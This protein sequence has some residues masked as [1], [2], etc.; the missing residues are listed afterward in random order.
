MH[1]APARQPTQPINILLV[2][3][4]PS[5][6][7][8]VSILIES[9]PRFKVVA[10]AGTPAEAVAAVQGSLHLAIVDLALGQ[11]ETG[12]D[13]IRSLREQRPGLP[14]LVLS[15]H[16]E[17]MHARHALNA[18]ALGYLMKDRATEHLHAAMTAVAA[19]KLWLSEALRNNQE[20][21]A[22]A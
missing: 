19:G 12:L 8:V 21:Q 18:G 5:L 15:M 4:R 6:R 1:P 7:R 11:T 3:D 17:E 22:Q 14:I 20:F 13:L 2:E 16:S 9:D 10:E